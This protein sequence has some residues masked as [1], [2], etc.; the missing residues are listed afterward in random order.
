MA[1]QEEVVPVEEVPD[2]KEKMVKLRRLDAIGGVAEYTKEHADKIL[3]LE[4][5]IGA[6]NYEVA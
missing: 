4:K 5:L 1:K 6:N 3:A 2:K